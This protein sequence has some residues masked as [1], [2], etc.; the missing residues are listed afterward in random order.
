MVASG[1]SIILSGGGTVTLPYTPELISEENPVAIDSYGFDD[2]TSD[3]ISKYREPRIL[4]LEGFVKGTNNGTVET[5]YL[6][7][8]RLMAGKAVTITSPNSQYGGTWVMRNPS[9]TTEAGD[10]L[11]K[12]N[13]RLEF[14]LAG[15]PTI[16]VT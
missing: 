15:T 11:V 4:T 16:Y 9:F 10:I 2:G 6:S 13:Y 14:M 5:D 7:P 12:F 8:L 1:W 3:L